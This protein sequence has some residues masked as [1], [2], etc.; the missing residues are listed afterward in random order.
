H[1][2]FMV[3]VSYDNFV[4]FIQRLSDRQTHQAYEGRSVHAKSNFACIACI[5]QISDTL[6]GAQNC[7][8][9]F[10]A[11]RV[12]PPS[13]HIALDE[14]MIHRVQRD[15]WNLRTGRVVEKDES[16]SPTQSW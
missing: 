8:V 5:H 10:T 11:F 2:S 13:L 3:H 16:R 9:H 4:S 6:A 15:L 14:M 7:R 12:A 1:V